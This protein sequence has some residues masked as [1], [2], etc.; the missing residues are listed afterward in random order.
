LQIKTKIV[1]CHT[2]DSKPVKQE[3]NGT[4][5]F[6]PLVFPEQTFL[7]RTFVNYGYKFFMTLPPSA[8]TIKTLRSSKLVCFSKPLKDSKDSSLLR[9][10]SIFHR[11]FVH[12]VLWYNYRPLVPG[13]KSLVTNDRSEVS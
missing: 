2:R 12:Y 7:L 11:L 10:L 1:S 5:I 6:P 8:R 4:V 9:N 13:V 3:V